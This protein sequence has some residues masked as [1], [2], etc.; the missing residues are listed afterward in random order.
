M[1]GRLHLPIVYGSPGQ[2]AALM[3]S[4]GR[5]LEHEP[6]EVFD[7]LVVRQAARQLA[8]L[9]DRRVAARSAPV[10]PGSPAEEAAS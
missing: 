10:N 5:V 8:G 4:L 3:D 2:V 6:D 9:I 1:T 7:D